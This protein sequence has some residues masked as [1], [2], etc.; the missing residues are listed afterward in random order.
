MLACVRPTPISRVGSL[1]VHCTRRRTVMSRIGAGAAAP[2][3]PRPPRRRMMLP[4]G[5]HALQESKEG[6]E[7]EA[8]G[9]GVGW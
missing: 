6:N 2:S 7:T 3:R 1:L 9:V 8:Q 4:G 5:L